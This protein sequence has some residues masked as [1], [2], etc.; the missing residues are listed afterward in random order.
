M[1]VLPV[2]ARIPRNQFHST[3]LIIPHNSSYITIRNDLP[4]RSHPPIRSSLPRNPAFPRVL[5]TL[6]TA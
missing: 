3:P 5:T 1:T 4:D 2:A 6:R